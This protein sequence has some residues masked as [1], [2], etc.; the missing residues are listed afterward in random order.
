MEKLKKLMIIILLIIV[1]VSILIILLGKLNQK[2]EES[3]I[4]I[5]DGEEI[6]QEKDENGYA[7]LNDYGLYYSINNILSKY[8]NIVTS[9]E[10]QDIEEESNK[11]YTD[12]SQNMDMIYSLLDKK[13]IN[14]Y[15]ITVNNVEKFIY[16]LDDNVKIIPINIKIKYGENI[17]TCIVNAYIIGNNIEEKKFIIRL[18]NKNETF[19]MEFIN[20]DD[21]KE[22][23]IDNEDRIQVNDYNHFEIQVATNE[24]IAM[25]YLE[26]Y[27]NLAERAPQIVYDNYLDDNY[28]KLKFESLE[29]FKK[30]IESNKEELESIRTNKYLYN[31]LGD[32]K[33]EYVCKDQY[34]NV[35]IF[36]INSIFDY[37]IKLD[38]YTLLTD[39]FK[40]EYKNANDS[41]KV[42]MNTDRFIQMLNRHDYKS[43]YN[44]ISNDFKNNYFGTE[45]EFVDFIKQHFFDYNNLS[46]KEFSKEGT[47]LFKYTISVEDLTENDKEV[48]TVNMIMQINN[49]FD[50]EIAFEM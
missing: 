29:E 45:E 12:Y 46:F 44:C 22:N 4:S 37:K 17:N 25:N 21:V 10:I 11:E 5:D 32:G 33:A 38:N 19:S 24:E 15:K 9:N 27:K 7:E 49:D 18:D 43:L 35:Y 3:N 26:Q 28:K 14:N 39:K 40:T 47:K 8:I 41:K 16:E 6:I 2:K 1:I 48:K 20:N 23:N 31:D 13:Y 30:Y 34:N 42:Q 50:F 36:D